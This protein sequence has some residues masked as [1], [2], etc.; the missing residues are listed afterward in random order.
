MVAA[1]V[2]ETVGIPVRLTRP[3]P[4]LH[5][6]VLAIRRRRTVVQ[7]VEAILAGLGLAKMAD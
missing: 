6:A 7:A 4:L 1:A 2:G 3:P 5:P